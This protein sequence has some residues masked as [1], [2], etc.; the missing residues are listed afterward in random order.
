MDPILAV[1]IGGAVVLGLT[2]LIPKLKEYIDSKKPAVDA[3]KSDIGM[4]ASA[5]Q[6]DVQAFLEGLGIVQDIKT[7]KGDFDAATALFLNRALS[8]GVAKIVRT[9]DQA[10]AAD[11]YAKAA[12]LI[13]GSG[14]TPTPAA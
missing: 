5:M 11:L 13:A 4:K 14:T 7:I 12:L 3:A 10:A 8:H 1:A 2:F 9:E 6:D